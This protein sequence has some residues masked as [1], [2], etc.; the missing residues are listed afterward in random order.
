MYTHI[1]FSPP[2]PKKLNLLVPP[3]DSLH[4]I[5]NFPVEYSLDLPAVWPVLP[6]V[7]LLEAQVESSLRPPVATLPHGAGEQRKTLLQGG[8]L[9]QAVCVTETV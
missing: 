4:N 1:R 8:R 5:F 2:L 9:N 6:E 7:L 3:L